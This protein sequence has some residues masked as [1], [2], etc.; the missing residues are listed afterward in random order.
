MQERP[1]FLL[2]E[3]AAIERSATNLRNVARWLYWVFSVLFWVALMGSGFVL[4]LIIAS[5]VSDSAS[6]GLIQLAVSSVKY[7]LEALIVLF[8]IWIAKSIFRDMKAGKSP[9]TRDEARKIKIAALLQVLHAVFVSLASPAV[10]SAVGFQDIAVGASIGA[11]SVT[12]AMR[13]IPINMGDIVLAIVLFC[14]ALIVEYGSLLQQLSD[15]T[16]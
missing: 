6:M 4:F 7:A 8:M 2:S 15:D 5:S 10:L 12:S 14:A 13:F 16:V 9:F 11:T 3:T 1:H